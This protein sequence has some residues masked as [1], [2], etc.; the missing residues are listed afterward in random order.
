MSEYVADTHALYWHIAGDAR[1]SETVR[2]ILTDVDNGLHRV[3]VPSIV[4]VEMTYLIERGRIAPKPLEHLL[5]ST[6]GDDASYLI[7]DLS[8]ETADAL[9][10]VPRRAIPDMP[11]RIIV[12]TALQLGLPLLS[13]DAAITRAGVVQTIW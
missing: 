12:A 1:L 5:W 9:R 7:A 10:R 13:R 11:D 8:R 3:W 2:G 6:L 4:L